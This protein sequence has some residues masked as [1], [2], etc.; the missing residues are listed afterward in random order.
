MV[1]LVSHFDFVEMFPEQQSVIL[2]G[3]GPSLT[4]SGLGEWIDSHEIVVRFN[5]AAVL[6]HVADVG[7]K[8]DI[9]VTNPYTEARQRQALDGHACKVVLVIAPPSR[10][11]DARS[12]QDWVGENRVFFTY[13][14]DRGRL[15]I[16]LA[17]GFTT[18]VAAL[19]LLRRLLA[20]R[21]LALT[22][23]TMFLADTAHSYWS[24][25]TPPGVAKHDMISNAQAL[26]ALINASIRMPVIVTSEI[27]WLAHMVQMELAKKVVVKELPDPKWTAE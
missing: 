3:N 6:D 19:I 5:E 11:G 7:R 27:R 18:G 22:G 17:G 15:Q 24:G 10:R 13:T 16:E 26:I 20:P 2:V 25:V 12:F 8:T 23:F 1:E 14:P 9:L 4:G 21:S